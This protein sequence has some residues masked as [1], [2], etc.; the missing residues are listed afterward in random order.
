MAMLEQ[1]E[2]QVKRLSAAGQAAL[3]DWLDHRL[4]DRLELKDACKT[5]IQAGM[6][7]IA[8]GHYRIHRP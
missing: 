4:E 3:R 5:E 2:D 8:N 1:V 7:S 6:A